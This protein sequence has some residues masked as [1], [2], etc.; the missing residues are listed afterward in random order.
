MKKYL[1]TIVLVNLLTA[2]GFIHTPFDSPAPK[3][4]SAANAPAPE[5]A[6]VETASTAD[7]SAKPI[8]KSAE[9]TAPET[10]AAAEAPKAEAVVTTDSVPQIAETVPQAEPAVPAPAP[11]PEAATTPAPVA[12]QKSDSTDPLNDPASALFKRLIHFPFDS[13]VIQPADKPTVAAH[14]SYLAGHLERKIRVTG[15]TDERGSSEY[16]LALGQRRAN[17]ARQVAHVRSH[18]HHHVC[19]ATHEA[20]RRF[21]RK[22][23]VRVNVHDGLGPGGEG[24]ELI[25][26]Y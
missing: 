8:E 10:A 20:A 24:D 12:S 1:F 7:V 22:E 15:N 18:L 21:R 4:E 17:N 23:R 6:K 14:G 26:A 3:K 13:D 5:A 2:C 25:F 16:N 11:V 19:A 9:T